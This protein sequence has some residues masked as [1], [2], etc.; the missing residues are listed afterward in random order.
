MFVNPIFSY[1]YTP[2]FQAK[3]VFIDPQ[4]LKE[5][6][7]AGLSY[8]QIAEKFNVSK[9]TIIKRCKSNGIYTGTSPKQLDYDRF[10]GKQI[11]D[12]IN[13]GKSLN[14]VGKILGV[15]MSTV[16]SLLKHFGLMTKQAEIISEIDEVQL[17]AMIDMGMSQKEIAKTLGIEHPGALTPLIKKY[18]KKISQSKVDNIPVGE[19][20]LYLK[21]GYSIDALAE[22]YQVSAVYIKKR[23]KALGLSTKYEDMSAISKNI[24]ADELKNCVKLGMTIDD[25]AKKYSLTPSRV[26]KMLNDCS[27]IEKKSQ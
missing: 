2:S 6:V 4:K 12:L 5:L 24:S 1:T 7:D 23:V 19:L 15:G 13:E 27:F 9:P 11:E 17:C 18:G 10:N 22:K 16:R 3:P 21:K 14:Q 8:T 26:K 25:I 20:E